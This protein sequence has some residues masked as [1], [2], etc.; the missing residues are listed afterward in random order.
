MAA[1]DHLH[2]QQ[3]KLFMTGTELKGEITSSIDRAPMQS[4]DDM[5]KRKLRESKGEHWHGGGTHASLK[6]R[7][8]VGPGPELFHTTIPGAIP[9]W[10]KEEL[11]VSDAHHRIAAAADI[12]K[13]SK[14]KRQIYIPTTNRS[15]FTRNSPLGRK[16][17][18]APSGEM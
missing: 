13:R 14:G 15:Q 1:S 7:G 5:W 6:E 10:D 11:G 2:P 16:M 12:E 8:W 18:N 3:M 17:P 4:M 9:E